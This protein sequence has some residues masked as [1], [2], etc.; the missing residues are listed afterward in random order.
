M[1]I[2]WMR[3]VW[4]STAI[5][6]TVIVVV[7]RS[8]MFRSTGKEKY[9]R[10]PEWVALI[11]CICVEYFTL[12]IVECCVKIISGETLLLNLRKSSL[13]LPT[14]W[15]KLFMFS[16]HAS[17]FAYVIRNFSMSLY[18]GLL[19]AFVAADDNEVNPFSGLTIV[20]QIYLA[21]IRGR[22]YGFFMHVFMS[23]FFVE[24]DDDMFKKVKERNISDDVLI[25]EEMDSSGES[26]KTSLK[27]QKKRNGDFNAV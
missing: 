21:I 18:F 12:G 23:P 15:R 26:E 10:S 8:E 5:C 4:T 13:R 6:Y 3:L 19:S 7:Y 2:F 27:K 16:Y 17:L 22:F 20:L 14:S 25:K 24:E 1:R 9:Y 11:S